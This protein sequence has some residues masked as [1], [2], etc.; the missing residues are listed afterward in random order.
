MQKLLIY[1]CLL[2]FAAPVTAQAGGDGVE[3]FK[4]SFEELQKKAAKEKTPYFIDFWATWCGPCKMMN[5][6][7][8]KDEKV[9]KWVK[10]RVIPYKLD[11]DHSPGKGLAKKYRVS[12][13]PTIIFFDHKGK[14][15]GRTQGYQNAEGFLETLEDFL[16]SPKK[17]SGKTGAVVDYDE[18]LALNVPHF[19]TLE[20]K[21][22][23]GDSIAAW[24]AT[25]FQYGQRKEDLMFDDLK[26][27]AHKA[28]FTDQLWQ[29]DA[30]YFAGAEDFEQ[31]EKTLEPK[32][33]D[34]TISYDMLLWAANVYANS[35]E[36]DET[37]HAPMRWINRVVR[38][39]PSAE[40]YCAKA[41]LLYKDGKY[42]FA[43]EVCEQALAFENLAPKLKKRAETLKAV[44]ASAKSS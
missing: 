16:G 44:V 24:G 28:G 30:Q 1:F 39:Q 7:T 11:V 27:K 18:Y 35:E 41:A 33:E 21:A 31:F 25:A 4:D 32:F 3:F 23:S 38:D 8:F 43:L 19:K 40:A 17:G 5:N 42:D 22:F 12:S 13:I 9:A 29:L 14:V 15:I 26:R 10:G 37:P 6:T 34:K 2:A 36:I 20:S